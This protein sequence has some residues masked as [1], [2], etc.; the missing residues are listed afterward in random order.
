MRGGLAAWRVDDAQVAAVRQEANGDPGVAEQPFQLGGGRVAPGPGDLLGGVKFQRGRVGRVVG[1]V[2]DQREEGVA[3]R[4]GRIGG[5]GGRVSWWSELGEGILAGA[6]SEGCAGDAEACAYLLAGFGRPERRERV[7]AD[8]HPRPVVAKKR[9]EQRAG[10]SQGEG[11]R[12]QLDQQRAELRGDL[13]AGCGRDLRLGEHR[14]R[15][16][17]AFDRLGES[18]PGLVEQAIGVTRAHVQLRGQLTTTPTGETS[19]L[20]TA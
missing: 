5:G 9:F 11:T 20:R 18:E 15:E 12:R 3:G 14:D 4:V 10:A 17:Q 16:H 2:P 8:Q 7:A 13:R 1:E 6:C 19:V